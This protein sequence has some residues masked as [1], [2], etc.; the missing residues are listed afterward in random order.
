MRGVRTGWTFTALKKHVLENCGLSDACPEVDRARVR[1]YV[2]A[3]RDLMAAYQVRERVYERVI[4]G[5]KA[6]LEKGAE[7]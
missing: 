4:K 5:H 2:E 1:L 6:A 3:A 7:G